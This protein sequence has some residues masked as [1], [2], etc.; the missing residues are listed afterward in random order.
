MSASDLATMLVSLLTTIHD[1]RFGFNHALTDV[2]GWFKSIAPFG[3][4]LD[5]AF[6][7]DMLYACNILNEADKF[8]HFE[9]HSF[10]TFLVSVLKKGQRFDK[11]T[12]EIIPR[13]E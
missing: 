8:K 5:E 4:D 12:N 11:D 3:I 10:D 1:N 6:V 2:K 7:E 13:G 9:G